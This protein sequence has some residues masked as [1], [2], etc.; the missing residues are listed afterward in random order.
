[1]YPTFSED[2]KFNADYLCLIWS[3]DEEV[4]EAAIA[5]AGRADRAKVARVIVDQAVAARKAKMQETAD[6]QFFAAIQHVLIVFRK[7][8]VAWEW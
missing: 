4:L 2:A 8:L 7:D 3:A 6:L 1:M 5:A